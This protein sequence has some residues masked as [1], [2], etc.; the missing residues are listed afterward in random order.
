MTDEQ[1]RNLPAIFCEKHLSRFDAWRRYPSLGAV[2]R[3]RLGA[4]ESCYQKRLSA[5]QC[6][7][8]EM[9]NYGWDFSF[10][11]TGGGLFS[12]IPAALTFELIG[13]T[14]G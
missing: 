9:L 8:I 1:I 10:I 11:S 12:I 7:D 13:G 5:G 14:H 4:D 3:Y 2:A 6:L